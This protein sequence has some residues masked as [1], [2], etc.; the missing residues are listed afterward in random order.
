M[1]RRIDIDEDRLA[2]MYN[3]GYRYADM[4]AELDIHVSFLQKKI[5][6]LGLPPRFRPVVIDIEEF[7]EAY[8]SGF[9]A[10]E[11]ASMFSISKTKV[12]S[13]ARELKLRERQI[14]MFQRIRIEAQ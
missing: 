13:L 6:E 14:E 7:E 4:C 11:L 1:A 8:L 9:S 2:E 12:T 3:A 5:K 10:P